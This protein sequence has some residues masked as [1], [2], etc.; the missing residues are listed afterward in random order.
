MYINTDKINSNVIF[1]IT[2]ISAALTRR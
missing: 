1:A 2:K